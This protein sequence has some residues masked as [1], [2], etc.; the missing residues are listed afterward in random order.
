MLTHDLCRDSGVSAK[1]T[2]GLGSLSGNSRR[3]SGTSTISSYIGSSANSNSPYRFSGQ[4]SRRSSDNSHRS[5]EASRTSSRTSNS[6]YEY[7]ISLPGLDSPRSSIASSNIGNM[8]MQ[9]ERT[10]LGS[11]PNL[12]SPSAMQQGQPSPCGQHRQ[13]RGTR[14]RKDSDCWSVGTPG[15]VLP[16]GH[17]QRVRRASDPV[18]YVG[19]QGDGAVLKRLQGGGSLNSVKPL[20]P[21][22]R[23]FRSQT[24]SNANFASSRSSIA[25]DITVATESDLESELISESINLDAD[26][27]AIIDQMLDANDDMLIPDEMR[28]YLNETGRVSPQVDSTVPDRSP[29]RQPPKQYAAQNTQMLGAVAPLNMSQMTNNNYTRQMAAQQQ[30]QYSCISQNAA[31]MVSPN[32]NQQWG[33]MGGNPTAMSPGAAVPCNN[34]QHPCNG[35][36]MQQQLMQQQQLLQQQLQQ[37]MLP[38]GQGVPARMMPE[39]YCYGQM[40][41]GMMNSQQ[42]M[43]PPQQT[44]QAPIQQCTAPWQPMMVQP[45]R[46]VVNGNHSGIM[47][48][49]QSHAQ[50]QQQQQQQQQCFMQQPTHRISEHVHAPRGH[51]RADAAPCGMCERGSPMV[52]VPQI[53]QSQIPLRTGTAPGQ[54]SDPQ[55][56]NVT[57][58]QS[59][60]QMH[61]YSASYASQPPSRA[62]FIAPHPPCQQR[63]ARASS[64]NRGKSTVVPRQQMSASYASYNPQCHQHQ[65]L[66]PNCSDVSSTTDVKMCGCRNYGYLA[67]NN[68]DLN[69]ISTDDLIDNLSSSSM[70]NLTVSAMVS[71]SA[72]I[73]RSAMSS[74]L[75]SPYVDSKSRAGSSHALHTSNMVVNHMSSMLTQLAEENKYLNNC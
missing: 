7:D 23:S 60:N 25:T 66:S 28:D 67:A 56:G 44:P 58:Q 17:S 69:A 15:D 70:E 50:Y 22:M 16:E 59:Y 4:F 72:L 12:L 1:E 32:T 33:A 51:Q 19:V 34:C 61:S 10:Q 48:M 9:L 55:L 57:P 3:D 68:P 2:L 73:N 42:L 65:Q 36:M 35:H 49:P 21:V 74:R 47:D 18:P 31:S 52:Q 71:P 75:V 11:N 13:E 43:P 62:A 63:P 39:G 41:G 20:P 38:N 26:E 5:S 45:M 64:R 40:G 30:Q 24:G 54:P 27:D 53:S 14:C 8:T 46:Q 29:T 37:Q 6:P